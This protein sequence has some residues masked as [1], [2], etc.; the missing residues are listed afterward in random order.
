[1]IFQ[2]SNLDIADRRLPQDGRFNFKVFDKRIDV[3]VSVLPT[4]YGEKIV[5]RLLDRSNLILDLK[6][7]GFHPDM[8]K[9]FKR[10]LSMSHGLV[11]LTGPT[12][13]GKT[14]TLYAALNG[15]KDPSKNIVTIEDPVEY[16]LAGVNQV[17]AKSD[18]G[19]SFASGLR[20]ILRQDPDIVMVGEIRDRETAEI[21]IRSSLTGHLV[22]STLHTNDSISAISRLVDMGIERYLLAATVNLVMSQRLVR[23]ICSDC[24]E[25]WEPPRE[26]LERL[27]RMVKIKDS[28]W[29]YKRGKG[30]S[31]CSGSGYRGRVAVYE[32]FVVTGK[33]RSLIADGASIAQIRKAAEKEGFQPLLH[34]ALREV[35]NGTTTLDEALRIC[36]SQGDELD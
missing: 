33:I 21:C 10:V 6:T 28:S 5:M 19:L 4:I 36:A 17:N 8:L 23:R 9:N 18:I 24:A 13:S 7:L 14:T 25:S 2:C 15:I 27:T 22:L 26:I 29:N 12:G 1:M 16:R 34:S 32:P 11:I 35:R 20:S 30:C 3:R 31:R